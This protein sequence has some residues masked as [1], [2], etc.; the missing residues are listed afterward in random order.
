MQNDSGGPE[1]KRPRHDKR[2]KESADEHCANALSILNGINLTHTPCEERER[3]AVEFGKSLWV[4]EITPAPLQTSGPANQRRNV[5]GA[6]ASPNDNDE[7]ENNGGDGSDINGRNSSRRR[8]R[9]KAVE[10]A[11]GRDEAKEFRR[12]TFEMPGTNTAI[13]LAELLNGQDW[14]NKIVSF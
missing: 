11:D 7:H 13:T 9:S 6:E 12:F 1:A 4:E 8:A 2:T 14:E 10:T 5:A 3:N